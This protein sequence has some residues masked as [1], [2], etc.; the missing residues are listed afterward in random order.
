M[1]IPYRRVHGLSLSFGGL[2][3]VA[4]D[5]S[6]PAQ[7]RNGALL[8][9]TAHQVLHPGT[10]RFFVEEN[11]FERPTKY[12]WRRTFSRFSMLFGGTN[13]GSKSAGATSSALRRC[14]VC[15]TGRRR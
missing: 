6:L 9:E 14:T 5:P 12:E 2:R 4:V 10:V 15:R 11:L 3:V 1:Q 7:R 8:H 13:G